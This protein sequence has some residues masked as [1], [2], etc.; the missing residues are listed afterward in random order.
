MTDATQAVGKIPL[1]V[2]AI[3]VDLLAASSH[4]VYGLAFCMFDTATRASAK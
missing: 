4:Q 1:D 3:Q 2:Q